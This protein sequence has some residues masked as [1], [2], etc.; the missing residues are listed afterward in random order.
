LERRGANKTHKEC[1]AINTAAFGQK[2][3]LFN[4]T[5]SVVRS[6]GCNSL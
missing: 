2:V 1:P 5:L 6:R 3:G 4:K